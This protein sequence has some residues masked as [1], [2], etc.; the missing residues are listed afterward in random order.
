MANT[1]EENRTINYYDQHATDWA[2]THGGN[3]GPSYWQAEMEGFHKLLPAGKILE[4]GS[5]A[6]KD[7]AALVAMGY[8]YT[9]TD[10]SAGL[11]EIARQRNPGAKFEHIG[12]HELSF[13]QHSFDGF[14]TVATL[15]HVPKSK[16]DK[17]LQRI[18]SQI[19]TGGIGFITIKAGTGEEEDPGTGRWF[20]YYSEEEFKNVLR[21][22][23]FEILAEKER[24][25]KDLWLCFWVKN[26]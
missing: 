22:N 25:E 12:V 10:A 13:P 17:A 21:R 15:L 19:K 9:G 24:P 6:G 2:T 3:K 5:G 26:L 8:S 14:W 18:R 11:L 16:I 4:V 1:K 7:A 23:Q 20:A